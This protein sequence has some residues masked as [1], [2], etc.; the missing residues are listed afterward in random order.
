LI[1]FQMLFHSG[2]IAGGGYDN[3]DVYGAALF[4]APLTFLLV[5][6]SVINLWTPPRS[7]WDDK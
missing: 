3:R 2:Q 5:Y 7:A 4:R 1:L 6:R